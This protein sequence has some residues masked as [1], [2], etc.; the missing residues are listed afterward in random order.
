MEVHMLHR[1]PDVT[2]NDEA[3]LQALDDIRRDLRH[4]LARPRRWQGT[5]RRQA[6]AR[7]VRG[8]NSIE[9]ISVSE[10]EAFAIVGGEDDQVSRL[11]RR[12]EKI[13]TEIDMN[14]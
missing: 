12:G 9:G 7:A 2:A 10:D 4:A 8:S 6:R 1:V 14:A 13:P 3:V 11:V 5:L